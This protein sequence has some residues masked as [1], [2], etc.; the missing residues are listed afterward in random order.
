MKRYI[1]AILLISMVVVSGCVGQNAQEKTDNTK[2]IA[3]TIGSVEE[4]KISIQN[5]EKLF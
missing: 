2:E 5:I 3:N 1:L 4:L